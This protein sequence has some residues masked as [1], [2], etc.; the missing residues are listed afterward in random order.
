MALSQID[1]EYYDEDGNGPYDKGW[2]RRGVRIIADKGVVRTSFF[3]MDHA[4][5]RRYAVGDAVRQHQRL[6]DSYRLTD[7]EAARY[8]PHEARLSDADLRQREDARRRWL[9][10]QRDAWKEPPGAVG[11]ILPPDDNGG[12]DEDNGDGDDDRTEAQK[13]RDEWIEAQSNAWRGAAAGPSLSHTYSGPTEY[14]RGVWSAQNAIKPGSPIAWA[15][16][17]AARRKTTRES[18]TDAGDDRVRAYSEYLNRIAT[19]WMR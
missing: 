15:Q 17:E 16:V 6:L 5:S 9:M 7:A 3:L 4:A 18:P 12:D 2:L 11:G 14:A 19:D 13:A 8:K 1:D 10:E